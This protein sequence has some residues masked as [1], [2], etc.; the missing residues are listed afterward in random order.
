MRYLFFLMVFLLLLS[1]CQ[2][3]YED[4][5]EEIDPF[6]YRR[7]VLNKGETLAAVMLKM[8]L[9]NASVYQLVNQLDKIYNLKKS[10][11]ADSFYVRLDTLGVIHELAYMPDLTTIYRVIRDSNDVLYTRIDTLQLELE[12][13]SCSGEIRS[14]LYQAMREAGEGGALPVMFSQIFQWDIDFFIDPQPGDQFKVIYERYTDGKK[15]IRYGQILAAQY[16]SRNYNKIAFRYRDTSGITKYYDEKGISFQKAFLKSPLN[17]KRISSYFGNRVH[18][19]T[20][21]VSFH[22]GVDYAAAYGTPVEAVADGTVIKASWSSNHTGNTVIIRHTNGYK[23]LYGHLSKYG[24]Y[25]VGDKVQQH[26]VVGY[27][28]STGRSTGNHLHY[29]IYQHDK[30]INPLSLNNVSGPPVPK[31]EMA[32]YQVLVDS[33]KLCLNEIILAAADSDDELIS[34]QVP[35]EIAPFTE[36]GEV[37]EMMADESDYPSGKSR[38]NLYLIFII[39]ILFALNIRLIFKIHRLRKDKIG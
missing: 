23:T 8:D 24:K 29:T 14:S 32:Q 16:I 38:I 3:K 20:K 28:G 18:P 4:T 2:D 36:N 7:G 17:Y 10:H 6:V 13:S 30:P 1:G 33:L 34:E 25:K 27:V 39:V 15:F 5:P 21:K 31:N 35:T 26:D 22:S 37:S 11:P 9:D 12:I 19:V